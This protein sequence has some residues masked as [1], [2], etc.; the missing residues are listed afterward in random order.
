MYLKEGRMEHKRRRISSAADDVEVDI[1]A[2][3]CRGSSLDETIDEHIEYVYNGSFSFVKMFF[4]S[5]VK[6]ICPCCLKKR[7]QIEVN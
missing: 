5:L 2:V 4:R 7:A 6:L 3:R 1:E